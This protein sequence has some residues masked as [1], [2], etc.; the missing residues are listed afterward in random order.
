MRPALDLSRALRRESVR[1]WLEAGDDERATALAEAHGAVVVGRILRSG[2]LAVSERAAVLA[3]AAPLLAI[4]A[5]G[6]EWLER[7]LRAIEGAPAVDA[8]LLRDDAESLIALTGAMATSRADE[9]AAAIERAL[10]ARA[11]QVDHAAM[12]TARDWS[13]LS[14]IGL[15]TPSARWLARAA[16]LDASTWWLDPIALAAIPRAAVR[17]R[18]LA[19]APSPS[20]ALRISRRNLAQPRRDLLAVAEVVGCEDDPARVTVDSG[21]LIARLFDNEIEVLALGLGADSD[22]PAGLCLRRRGGGAEGITRVEVL[23]SP[24]V[25]PSRSSSG[26]WIPFAGLARDVYV[27]VEMGDR[28][29]E[30]LVEIGD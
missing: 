15:E 13:G 1:Q 8:A 11:H 27:A 2:D 20:R 9:D 23:A 6:L 24:Q 10:L 12:E 3:A 25:S 4:G 19:V 16:E 26:W 30:V 18:L 21:T 17:A 14:S 5:A 7:A 28:R 22:L 29:E